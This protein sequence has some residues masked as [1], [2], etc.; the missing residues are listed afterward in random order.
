MNVN[1]VRPYIARVATLLATC[2]AP[3]ACGGGTTA[4]TATTTAG[5]PP[6]LA[7]E[8]FAEPSLAFSPNS[9]TI[10][11]GGSVT[12]DFEAVPHNAYFD[13][14]PTGAPANITGTNVNVSKTLT[15]NTVGTFV[16]NCHIHPGMRGT[17]IVVAPTT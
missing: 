1:T 2:L 11:R 4:A 8:V 12:I 5:G 16:Y 15:F 13:D 17:V 7:A 3:L 10:Q 14:Q 6:P 9:V